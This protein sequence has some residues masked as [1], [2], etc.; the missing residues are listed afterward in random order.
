MRI[1]KQRQNILNNIIILFKFTIFDL[2][3]LMLVEE[4][5]NWLLGFF[6]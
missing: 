1:I 4:L 2:R 3:S 5:I 6:I